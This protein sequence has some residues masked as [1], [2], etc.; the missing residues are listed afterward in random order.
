MSQSIQ[1]TPDMAVYCFD[2]LHAHANKQ[3]EPPMPT[4]IPRHI[5]CPL[6][7]TW[8]KGNHHHLRG[9]IGTF[10]NLSLPQGLREY[11][12]TSAF[13]DSRFEP[14]SREEISHLHCG[15]S[16]LVDFEPA[17]DYLDWVVGIH[18]IRINFWDGAA[19]RNAV[20]LP[21]VA[22]EQG[23]KL[24]PRWNHVET[25]DNLI[26]KGGYKGPID[27]A[28]RRAVEVVRFQS[29]KYNLSYK[30][31]ANIKKQQIAVH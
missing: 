27:E 24:L 8:K 18:G 21:E 7:V 31:Y 19:N 3:K 20:Y 2:I 23:T 4:S 12:V 9:C 30:D 13:H 25:L 11:A 15:V 28:F 10:S 17:R 14:I 26:Q 29:S 5:K 16:L 22:A 1:A 6:F